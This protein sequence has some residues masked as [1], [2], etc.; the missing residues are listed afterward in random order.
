M[1]I[2]IIMNSELDDWNRLFNIINDENENFKQAN[3]F[4]LPEENDIDGYP[5]LISIEKI[6]K[7]HSYYL[8]KWLI[9]VR[10]VINLDDYNFEV[11]KK[12]KNS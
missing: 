11:K 2:Y 1:I 9:I 7:N 3:E 6:L 4:T 5:T 10:H 12:K 8:N